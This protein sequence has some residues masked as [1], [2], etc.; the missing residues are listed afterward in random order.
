[1]AH[2]VNDLRASKADTKIKRKENTQLP[3]LKEFD[4]NEIPFIQ[5]Q[6]WE[7]SEN[8]D[9]A[10]GN[11]NIFNVQ[12]YDS[13]KDPEFNVGICEIERSRKEVWA[14][15]HLCENLDCWDHFMKEITTV[16]LA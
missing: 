8:L 15:C 16:E 10:T 12:D 13:D 2:V 1:M 4:E 3:K 9:R 14:A 7:H 6:Q 11:V 5:Q